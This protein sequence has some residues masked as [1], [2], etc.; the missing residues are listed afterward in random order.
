MSSKEKQALRD[1]FR[2]ALATLEPRELDEL[3]MEPYRE[4]VEDRERG[5]ARPLPRKQADQ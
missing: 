3:V 1:V 5:A 4:L 2:S